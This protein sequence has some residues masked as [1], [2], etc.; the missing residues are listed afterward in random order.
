[1]QTARQ[2]VRESWAAWNPQ[3]KAMHELQQQVQSG[4]I[5]LQD[6]VLAQRQSGSHAKHEPLAGGI[7][8][9]E[10]KIRGWVG[11]PKPF[12]WPAAKDA[13][14]RVQQHIEPTLDPLVLLLRFGMGNI[15][16]R[17]AICTA[18]RA[19]QLHKKLQCIH[20]LTPCVCSPDSA[21]AV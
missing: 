18:Y 6:T 14:V 16:G 8:P 17:R 2:H 13:Q 10:A 9:S 5:T 11:H 21:A 15:A 7:P 1:M 12:A 20:E 4:H 3:R 19:W